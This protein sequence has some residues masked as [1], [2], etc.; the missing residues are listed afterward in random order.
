MRVKHCVV[1]PPLG[2]L[3][4]ARPACRDVLEPC[5]G[6]DDQHQQVVR[7]VCALYTL[8]LVV[9]VVGPLAFPFNVS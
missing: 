1:P 5:H 2:A 3:A 9:V 7:R 8:R 6:E 4:R